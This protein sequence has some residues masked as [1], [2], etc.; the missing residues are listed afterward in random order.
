MDDG[1][2]LPVEADGVFGGCGF[3]VGVLFGPGAVEGMHFLCDGDV[4]ASVGVVVEDEVCCWFHGVSLLVCWVGLM[5]G[6]VEGVVVF[7]FP[8]LFAFGGGEDDGWV[9]A[10]FEV[11]LLFAGDVGAAYV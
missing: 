1:G 5:A 11:A 8:D 10:G 3:W 7:A 4:V 2:V 6:G 9:V